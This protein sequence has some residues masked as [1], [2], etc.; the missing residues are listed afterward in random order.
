MDKPTILMCHNFYSRPGGENSVY[1]QQRRGLRSRGH[2]VVELNRDNSTLTGASSLKKASAMIG[3]YYSRATLRDVQAIIEREKP[4]LALVQNTFPLLSPSLYRAIS[5]NRIPIIQA[6]YNYRLVC[7][8]AHLYTNGRICERCVAGSHLHA[9][10]NRC[11]RGS[12]LMSAWY[13]S[14]LKLHQSLDT[15]NKTID[16]FMVPD[17]FAVSKLSGGGISPEKIRVNV[18]PFFVKDYSPSTTVGDYALYVGRLNEQKGVRTLV[19]AV[20]RAGGKSALVIAG[21]GPLRDDVEKAAEASGGKIR[22]V[23][24]AWGDDLVRLMAAARAVV[25]PS[26]WYDNLPLIICQAN[27]MAKPVIASR[28]NGIPEYVAAGVNG[29]L[30]E[31]GDEVALGAAIDSLFAMEDRE[32]TRV[33]GSAREYAESVFDY[34]NH[35]DRLSSMF[36]EL[37][38]I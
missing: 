37:T 31:T 4:D 7:A 2:R 8:N 25:V 29:W 20:S 6:V 30:F 5:A 21:D 38:R 1:E 13:A 22:F 3:S 33:G 28:I 23:G 34:A 16:R 9:V 32:L 17:R 27:A 15:F 11:Y 14:I 12:T 24:P 36:D 19:R 10:A 26:E 35:Y 18:N